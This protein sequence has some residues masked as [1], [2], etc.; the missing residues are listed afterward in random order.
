[1]FLKYKTHQQTNKC[2][3]KA[4]TSENEECDKCVILTNAESLPNGKLSSGGQILSFLTS[5]IQ[6]DPGHK[7][8]SVLHET[9]LHLML[10]WIYCN[11]Y[12]Q[13]YTTVRKKYQIF[14]T[15]IYF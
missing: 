11:V 12:T 6:T 2:E 14:T 7:K 4:W 8:D 15:N 13:S 3:S 9:T 10:H 1:M 5:R